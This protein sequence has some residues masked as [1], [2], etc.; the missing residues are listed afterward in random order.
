[1]RPNYAGG[2]ETDGGRRCPA[3]AA[4]AEGDA[5]TVDLMV[6]G[7]HCPSCSALVE[8]TLLADPGV[9]QAVVDLEA[10]RASVTFDRGAVSVDDLCAAVVGAG[11]TATA[12]S[13]Q[14]PAPAC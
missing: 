13:A 1:M 14:D 11:Y 6:S 9:R 3:P 10:G 7:M 4:A 2:M 5:A 12:A 8:E